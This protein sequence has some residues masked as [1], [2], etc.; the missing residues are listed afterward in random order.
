V[1]FNLINTIE[2][3]SGMEFGFGLDKSLSGIFHTGG[4]LVTYFVRG[5]SY[6]YTVPE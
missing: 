6:K 1:S 4:T 3:L 2:H 5:I